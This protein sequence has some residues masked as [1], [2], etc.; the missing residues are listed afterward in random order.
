MNNYQ[1]L[2]Y[3]E[4]LRDKLDKD[5]C[6]LRSDKILIHNDSLYK[7]FVRST[8]LWGMT[9]ESIRDYIRK[10]LRYNYKGHYKKHWNLAVEGGSRAFIDID[11]YKLLFTAIERRLTDNNLKEN[12]ARF[13]IQASRAIWRLLYVREDAPEGLTREQAFLFVQEAVNS[14]NK[15]ADKGNFSKKFFQAVQLFLFLLRFRKIENN[16]LDPDN[17]ADKKLFNNALSCLEKANSYY[18]DKKGRDADRA[19]SLINGIK[20]Y[21]YYEG[22]DDIIHLLNEFAGES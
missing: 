20:D 3:I 17:S 1:A 11:D 13:P 19:V 2:E 21:M 9:P 15:E 5:F 10:L 14:M 18:K 4:Q 12:V 6:D 22:N 16:F 7:I 8:W